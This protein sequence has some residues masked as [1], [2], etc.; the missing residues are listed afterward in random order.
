MSL[1]TSSGITDPYCADG[2]CEKCGQWYCS[3][4]REAQSTRNGICTKCNTFMKLWY[5]RL[6]VDD[7]PLICGYCG[8]DP[9]Y[10]EREPGI[11]IFA[12]EYNKKEGKQTVN[13]H[14]CDLIH[15]GTRIMKEREVK[16]VD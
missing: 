3:I 16:L 9:V 1:I 10:I 6:I 2:I 12:I 8:K 13:R 5:R 4:V 7:K 14:A 11:S 15:E